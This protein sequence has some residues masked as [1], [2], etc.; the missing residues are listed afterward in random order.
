MLLERVHDS[1]SV[2]QPDL[3]LEKGSRIAKGGDLLV[4]F[5]QN[6]GDQWA[7]LLVASL[8]SNGEGD[9]TC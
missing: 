7:P 3:V 6:V 1:T 2:G 8:Y 9:R 5:D 4:E